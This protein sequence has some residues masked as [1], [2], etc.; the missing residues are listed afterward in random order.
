MTLA[1]GS[2]APDHR[3][4]IGMLAA[5]PLRLRRLFEGLTPD[6]GDRRPAPDDWSASEVLLHLVE[7]DRDIFVPRLRRMVAEDGPVFAAG[8]PP[9]AADLT[10]DPRVLLDVFAQARGQA[11]VIV[12]GLDASGWQRAGVSPSRGRLS[13]ETYAADMAAHDRE[14]LCQLNQVRAAHG[15]RVL[16]CEAG[17]PLPLEAIIRTTA[18]TPGR[19]EAAVAGLDAETLRTRPTPGEWSMKEVMAHLLAVEQRLFLPRLRRMQTEDWPRFEPFDP[20]AWAVER[21]WRAGDLMAELAEFREARQGTLGFLRALTPDDLARV[22]V[23]A[24][25]GAVSIHEY[26]THVAEHDAEHLA[27]LEAA[28]R[29]LSG[30]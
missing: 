3:R 17:D 4:I 12:E 13:I 14:H 21:D 23:S 16:R 18:A 22:G 30:R 8:R 9:R 20:D 5:T 10:L 28:R 15:L 7:G 25:F 19:I 26:A 24:G 29:V 11:V 27:Q 6:L 1:P 2:H